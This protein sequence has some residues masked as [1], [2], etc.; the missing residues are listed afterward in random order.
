MRQREK[1]GSATCSACHGPRDRPRQR[2]C[3]ACHA[4]YMREHRPKHSAL[5]PDARQRANARAYA[6]VYQR[7]GLLLPK[8]CEKCGS[9]DVQKHHDDYSKPLEVRWFCRACHLGFHA[10]G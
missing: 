4:A 3:K 6:N 5:P 10:K 8:P 9:E 1:K 7:R 2:Y